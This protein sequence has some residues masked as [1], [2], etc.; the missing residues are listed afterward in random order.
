MFISDSRAVEHVGQRSLELLSVLQAMLPGLRNKDR[1][2]IL[3]KFQVLCGFATL[4]LVGQVMANEITRQAAA[5]MMLECQ[6]EREENIAPHK[7]KAIDDCID[8]GRGDRAYCEK[9]NRNYGERTTGGSRRGMF[10]ELTV[11]ENAVSAEKYFKMNPGKKV[12]S[13]P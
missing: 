8:K 3:L 6:S 11:C 5:D 12:Y 2:M 13:L 9:Y 1:I 10:W 4:V 7:E